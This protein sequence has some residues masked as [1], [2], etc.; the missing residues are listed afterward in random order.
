LG[1]AVDIAV[2]YGHGCAL[3][4]TGGVACWGSPSNLGAQ[5]PYKNETAVH[6]IGGVADATTISTG[7]NHSC[8]RRKDG[9]VVCWGQNREGQLG[10]GTNRPSLADVVVKGMSDAVDVR[11]GNSHTCA[12]RKNGDVAC[13]GS[14]GSGQVGVFEPSGDPSASP[15]IPTSIAQIHNATS[16]AA[17]AMHTCAVIGGKVTCWGQ[18]HHGAIMCS[19]GSHPGCSG[20]RFIDVPNIGDAIRISAGGRKTCVLRSSAPNSVTC[21]SRVQEQQSDIRETSLDGVTA[22]AVEGEHVCA[23]SHGNAAC[24]GRNEGGQV[25]APPPYRT[26][27]VPI[28]W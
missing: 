28:G 13:W 26:S 20:Q 23:V 16:I 8:A 22:L 15:N 19:H 24:W 6:A 4:P 17:G 21:W 11:C 27:A 12:L 2:G 5:L 14:N 3:L 10:D 25:G 18:D 7:E 1:A 9:T